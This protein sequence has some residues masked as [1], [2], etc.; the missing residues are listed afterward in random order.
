MEGMFCWWRLVLGLAAPGI[1]LRSCFARPRPPY[2]ARRGTVRAGHSR[3]RNESGAGGGDLRLWI[4][5][6]AGMACGAKGD[7]V[8]LWIPA[9]AG[10]TCGLEECGERG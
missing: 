7:G 6:C 10:M 4:P 3:L 1:P 9:C 5:A 8:R 2:A